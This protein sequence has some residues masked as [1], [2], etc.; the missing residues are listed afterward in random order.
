MNIRT[1]LATAFCCC[2]ALAATAQTHA[3]PA[4]VTFA[5]SPHPQ[6]VITPVSANTQPAVSQALAGSLAPLQNVS[7]FVRNQS[8]QPVV[9]L[10]ATWTITDATG[11]KHIQRF[12]SDSFLDVRTQH[13][14]DP[15]G[16]LLVGPRMFVGERHF[17]ALAT[18]QSLTKDGPGLER[19]AA[20]VSAASA[21]HVD[22]ALDAVLFAN[23]ELYGPDTQH[24]VED[25]TA[26]KAAADAI[27]QA[28]NTA[29]ATG[30][31][32]DKTLAS[33]VDAPV[34]RGDFFAT[35]KRRF[36]HQLINSAQF[37][38]TL[39]YFEHLPQLPTITKKY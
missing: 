6:I 22:V 33:I 39:G 3:T 1:T 23:G 38:A 9:A 15:Q 10:V 2:F 27:V 28:V 21:S 26:R 14:I 8:E 18:R 4:R 25:L 30:L 19:A 7:F 12:S 17:Q 36:A 20:S 37:D 24:L 35:W 11:Q 16:Q 13:V 29:R 5:A 31:S 34:R 32:P